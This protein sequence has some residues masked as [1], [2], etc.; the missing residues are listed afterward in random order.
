MKYMKQFGIILIITFLGEGLKALIPLPIPASI[1]GL[2][3][4]LVALMTGIIK[5]NDVKCTARFLIE[6]MPLMFIPAAVGIIVEWQAL[7]PI[8]GPIAVITLVSTVVVMGVAGRV[9]QYV[10]KIG[11]GQNDERNYQ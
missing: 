8:I 6:I 4:M 2:V 7:Q 9:T 11:K 10:N 3:L 5:L 1:Y